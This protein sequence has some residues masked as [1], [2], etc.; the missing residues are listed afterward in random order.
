MSSAKPPTA[1]PPAAEP[2]AAAATELRLLVDAFEQWQRMRVQTGERIRAV[3]QGRDGT[4]DPAQEAEEDVDQ[5]LVRIRRGE[6]DGPQ[7]M[8]AA[9]YRTC[10][11]EEE[12]FTAALLAGLE[13][14][15]AWPWLSQVKGVGPLLG[16]KLLSRLDARR[17]PTPSSFWA[18]CGLATV[19]GVEYRCQTCGRTLAFPASYSVTGAHKVQGGRRTC[20]G[21]LLP[22]PA[23]VR[24]AQP[25]VARGEAG[26]YNV[27][28]KKVCYLL[29][30]SFLRTRSPYSREYAA[31]RE[32]LEE[33]HPGWDPKRR[34]LTAM[35]RM[36]KRFLADLWL[37][38]RE[39]LG[40]PTTAPYA[41]ARLDPLPAGV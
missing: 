15:P 6:D 35:R 29:G 9:M 21:Q 33:L 26:A 31:H 17:A 34:H 40:L 23:R 25:R 1:E 41:L 36:E 20:G 18:Y 12:S 10:Y 19:P 24:V 22:G 5:V 14:H 2:P 16:A 7:P 39:A 8:L 3:L 37:A 28:A 11:R 32:R 27:F 4:A 13:E 38:W 30:V